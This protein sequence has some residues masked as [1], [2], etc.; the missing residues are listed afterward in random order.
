MLN[1]AIAD[2]HEIV[3]SGLVMLIDQR[4]DMQVQ[5]QAS[6][7][8][9]LI[10]LLQK[11]PIDLLILDL[12]LG[13]KNGLESIENVIK[14]FPTLPILILSTYP[15]DPYAIQTFKAGASGYLNKTVIS[16]ELVKA[17]L[18][19]TQGK[20]YVSESLAENLAYGFN[21]EK[22]TK[23][24][25]ELLSKRE[26]EILTLIASGQAY[27]EIADKLDISPKTV[28]TYRTRILEKLNLSSTSQLLRFAYEQN[29]TNY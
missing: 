6:S 7:Y 1:I 11:E 8:S 2:D 15:E 26:F 28:S 25:V 5:M 27:K 19:I 13:D 4:E 29:I 17:I 9:E 3:R 10:L 20:K 24:L 18:K 14:F 23:N 16:S 21:L 22:S 12:N